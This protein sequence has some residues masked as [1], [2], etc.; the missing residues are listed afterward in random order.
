ME[1]EG[2]RTAVRNHQGREHHDGELVA[3]GAGHGSV[4]WGDP[5]SVW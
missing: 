4:W 2:A 3:H 1:A 5:E